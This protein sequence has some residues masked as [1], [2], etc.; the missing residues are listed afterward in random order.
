VEALYQ[1]T[2]KRTPD[3]AGKAQYVRALASGQISRADL[4]ASFSDSPEH[5]NLVAQRAAARD[6]SGL[7]LDVTPRLGIIPVVGT[8]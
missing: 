7:Y 6:A 8:P 4:L 5:I 1:N 2:L 3:A